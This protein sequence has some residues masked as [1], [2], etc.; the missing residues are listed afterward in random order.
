MNIKPGNRTDVFKRVRK[1]EGSG[2]RWLLPCT[3]EKGYKSTEVFFLERVYR[4]RYEYNA[5]EICAR[6]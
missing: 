3:R 1:E 6:H 2:N 4:K 5:F